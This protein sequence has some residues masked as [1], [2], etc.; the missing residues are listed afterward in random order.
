MNDDLISRQAAIDAILG[1]PPEPHYPSW[2]AEQI[3]DLPSVQPERK[4]G[5]WINHRN[6]NGHNIADCNQCG[7]AIQ[8]FDGDETPKYCCMCGSYNGGRQDEVD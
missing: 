4:T 5:K 6:D 2:Y 7:H 3:K 8:W 1:Q